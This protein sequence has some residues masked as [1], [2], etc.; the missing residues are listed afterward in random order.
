MN[1]HIGK[2]CRVPPPT[3]ILEWKATLDMISIFQLEFKCHNWYSFLNF[4]LSQIC[5]SY[6]IQ[7]IYSRK[8]YAN[9]FLPLLDSRSSAWKVWKQ[10]TLQY[11]WSHENKKLKMVLVNS[12]ENVRFGLIIDSI[13]YRTR[14]WPKFRLFVKKKYTF[15]MT[16]CLPMTNAYKV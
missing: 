16:K 8:S 1:C 11:S 6:V 7:I 10:Q 13:P 14:K 4:P 12:F 5:T 2:R 9:Y 15:Q 3:C